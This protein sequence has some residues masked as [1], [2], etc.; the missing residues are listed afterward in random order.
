MP[1]SFPQRRHP[2]YPAALSIVYWRKGAG[3]TRAGI[4]RTLN[5]SGGG[6]C[7]ELPEVLPLGTSLSVDLPT[8]PGELRVDALVVWVGGPESPGGDVLHGVSFIEVTADQHQALWDLV[9]RLAQRDPAGVSVPVRL[10]VL[11]RPQ[12]DGG[13]P[14]QGE[15]GDLGRGGLSVRLNHRLPPDT[16]VELTLPTSKGPRTMEASVVWL[17]P[18]EAQRPGEPIWH[19]LRFRDPR[20]AA[21][22]TRAL[23]LTEVPDARGWQQAG[24]PRLE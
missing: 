12:G 6:A 16:I 17:A 11:C 5:V 13:P 19:G 7:L 23:L 1:K 18:E 8:D 24:W 20:A 10:S 14:L 9:N 3:P 4:G 15:T 2:R 21:K 22:L